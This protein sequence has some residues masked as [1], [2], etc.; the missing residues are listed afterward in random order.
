MILVFL[1]NI[2]IVFTFTFP[3]SN[4]LPL[5][6]LRHFRVEIF[7]CASPEATSVRRMNLADLPVPEGCAPPYSTLPLQVFHTVSNRVTEGATILFSAVTPVPPL[8]PSPVLPLCLRLLSAFLAFMRRGVTES[9]EP[10]CLAF[11]L[12]PT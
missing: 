3:F 5:R 12:R 8:P 4:F 9:R 6:Y 1:L 11:V 2:C 10:A 7:T